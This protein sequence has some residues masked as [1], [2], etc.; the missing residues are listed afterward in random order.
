MRFRHVFLAGGSALVLAA[1]FATDPD[2]GITTG[3]LLL[4]LVTPLL[5]VAFA[6]LARKA[7]HDY[8]EADARKL[9]AKASEEPTGSGLALV[10]LAI[11]IYG[12]LALFGS[13]AKAQDVRTFI[14]PQAEL[15]RDTLRYELTSA[16]PG[17]PMP[18]AV[19][20]LIEHESCISLTH[21]RCWNAKSRLKT[22]RE[23]GAG[24]GQIT[25]AWNPDGSLRFDALAEMRARH[26]ELRE[27]SWSNVYQ[28]PDLQLRTLVLMS[29]DNYRALGVIA[30]PG[31]RL[32]FADAAYNGGL[33]GVQKDRRACQIKP[34]CD[35]QRWWGNVELTCTKSRVALYGQRSACDINR[36][37]VRD[38]L[39]VRAPKYELWL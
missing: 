14:P 21:S 6:H 28:R 16:W 34:G 29:R 3:M 36:H 4:S 9:F 13:V 31:Q 20:A 15:H 38:V 8:P 22:A 12:L 10:A 11:V 23:E 37:H 39:T 33:G 17:H 35:P 30:D 25:R 32:A 1:L 2:R 18:S 7:L 27:L 26:S 5:A 19:P 24:L